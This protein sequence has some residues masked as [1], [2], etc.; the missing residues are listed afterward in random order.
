MKT[1]LGRVLLALV[2]LAL[3]AFAVWLMVLEAQAAAPEPA[4]LSVVDAAQRAAERQ[5]DND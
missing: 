1:K 5:S 3:M 2:I 4:P